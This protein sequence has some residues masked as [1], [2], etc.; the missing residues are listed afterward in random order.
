MNFMFWSKVFNNITPHLYVKCLTFRILRLFFQQKIFLFLF[1][2]EGKQVFDLKNMNTDFN[3][4]CRT[5]LQSESN[6]TPLHHSKAA[7]MLIYCNF[8]KVCEDDGFP[9]KICQTC[10]ELLEKSYSFKKLCQKSESILTKTFQDK[11]TFAIKNNSE[12]CNTQSSLDSSDDL[13]RNEIFNQITDLLKNEEGAADFSEGEAQI[14]EDFISFLDDPLPPPLPF[15]CENCSHSFKEEKDLKIHQSVHNSDLTCLACSKKFKGSC[16]YFFLLFFQAFLDRQSLKRHLKIHLTQ[17]PHVCK[18]CSKSFSESYALVK[19]LRRHS[20]IPREKRHV[21]GECGQ[22]FSEPYYLKVHVRKH[23]GERPLACPDC[24]K[25]FADPRSLKTHVMIHSGER[26][27]KCNYCSK[28]FI[29]NANLTKHLRVHTG[30]KP[31]ACGLCDKRFTQS[32]NL[33]KHKKVYKCR[34][35]CRNGE[36]VSFCQ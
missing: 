28:S 21:C 6:L 27:F 31:Y 16:K 30:E 23:T 29:Q 3:S 9:D 10:L 13:R 11:Q 34:R 5:C 25:T 18:I 12:D 2:S 26:P 8:C 15:Q 4:V 7:E 19:H 36:N 24:D 14:Q 33:E 17:K 35:K 20:G 1:C 22:G 32:S